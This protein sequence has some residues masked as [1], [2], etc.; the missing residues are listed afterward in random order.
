MKSL[1]TNLWFIVFIG[2]GNDPKHISNKDLGQSAFNQH[3]LELLDHYERKTDSINKEL[4]FTNQEFKVRVDK[5]LDVYR[6]YVHTIHLLVNISNTLESMEIIQSPAHS[7]LKELLMKENNFRQILDYL[8]SEIINLEDE[9]WGIERKISNRYS[10]NAGIN[11][12]AIP[13]YIGLDEQPMI[14]IV[15]ICNV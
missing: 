6:K 12:I 14:K 7:S 13:N 9:Q 2:N 1:V 4:E 8:N 15:V 10:V 3:F 11:S 5:D